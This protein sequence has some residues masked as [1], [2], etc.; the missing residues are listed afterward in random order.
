MLAA[1][2]EQGCG[3]RIRGALGCATANPSL[4]D[5]DAGLSAGF[6]IS[7]MKESMKTAGLVN[8]QFVSICAVYFFMVFL[9]HDVMVTSGG[10]EKCNRGEVVVYWGWLRNQLHPECNM[11][12][13]AALAKAE[14]FAACESVDRSLD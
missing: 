14:V 13:L 7:W 9:N 12:A 2:D 11:T 6:F 8:D 3:T 5:E 10:P 1:E 4:P